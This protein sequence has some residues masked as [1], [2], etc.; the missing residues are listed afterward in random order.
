MAAKKVVLDTNFLLIP[1]QFKVDIF[2]ELNRRVEGQ[3]ELI[4]L[5]GC[6]EEL[7]KIK[8]T[9]TGKNKANAKLTLDIIK[10]KK[11]N[12][13]DHDQGHIDDIIVDM[14]DK[15]TIVCTQDKGL[16]SRLKEKGIRIITLRQKKYL[17]WG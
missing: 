5:K 10:T 13:T 15:D 17:T 1:A 6:L 9:Q 2:E 14:A 12:I 11:L 16:K 7:E 4:T 3:F 8:E